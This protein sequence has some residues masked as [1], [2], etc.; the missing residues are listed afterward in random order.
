MHRIVLFTAILA[1][2]WQVVP[3]AHAADQCPALSTQTASTD[4]A[5]RIA[6]FACRE[7]L[8]W[9][10]PFIDADG[11]M[12]SATVAEGESSLLADRVTPAWQRVAAYWRDSGL[13]WRMAQF[14]GAGQCALPV[15]VGDASPWCRAFVIDHPW[16]AAFVSYVMAKAGLPGF[17]PSAAH[18]D[19]VRDAWLRPATS[20]FLY[21]D[22]AAATPATGDLLCA[23]RGGQPRGHAGVVEAI[24]ADGRALNM[25]CDIVVAVNP[26]GDGKAYLIGGNVQQGVT[27][28]LLNLNRLGRFWALPRRSS[29]DP[30]CSPDD[31]AACNFNRQDWAALLKLK[32]PRE[33]AEL[34]Y[35]L[36][37]MAAP[38]PGQAAPMC[39]V[40]CVL[41]A[42]VPRCPDERDTVRP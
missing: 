11:R 6:A 29:V 28:R 24:D 35:L 32:P 21:Q 38:T 5:T 20:P 16:S 18:F 37:P 7:N 27:M 41:G 2:A 17:R 8:L 12:A 14:D 34:P 22:P 1:A 10:R 19:Y 9:Y 3:A 23:V 30:A 33:L 25:H 13:L 40:N 4:T 15:A 42:P 31:A 39:C 26:G 36:P